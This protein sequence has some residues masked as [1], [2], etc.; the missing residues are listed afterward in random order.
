MTQP[1]LSVRNLST[2]FRTE[3]GTVRAVDGVSFT[4]APAPAAGA[5]LVLHPRFD[6]GE[7]IKAIREHHCTYF[8]A[9]PTMLQRLVDHPGLAPGDLS[10]L[11]NPETVAE[12]QGK[13]AG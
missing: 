12:L 7:C 11:V 5:T 2:R 9:V 6:P 8:P 4:L 13:L 1:L 10:S 3:R